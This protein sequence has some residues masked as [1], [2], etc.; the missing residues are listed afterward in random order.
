MSDPLSLFLDTTTPIEDARI[1]LAKVVGRELEVERLD[2]G[3]VYRTKLLDI[4]MRF[5]ENHDLE[6]DCGIMFSRY[7]YQLMLISFESG[8]R[9]QGFGPMYESIA[10]FLGA[11]LANSLDCRV[12]VVA[13][14]QRQVAVFPPLQV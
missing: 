7:A 6:D 11:R 1:V 4:E 3:A 5:F 9:T 10:F 8:N 14:L 2:V 13:N 12:I